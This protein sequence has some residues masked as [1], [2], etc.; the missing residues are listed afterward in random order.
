M[1]GDLFRRDQIWFAEKNP[2]GATDLYSLVEYKINKEISVRNDASFEKD[3]LIGKYGA[4]PY[5]G[6]I[7]KFLNE[8]VHEQQEVR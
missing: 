5:F 8:F 2:I 4:I 6:N 7:E 1:R 3:Y